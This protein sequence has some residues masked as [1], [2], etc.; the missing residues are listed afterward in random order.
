MVR[1]ESDRGLMRAVEVP[2]HGIRIAYD[3]NMHLQEYVTLETALMRHSSQWEPVLRRFFADAGQDV[4]RAFHRD[5]GLS[6]YAYIAELPDGKYLWTEIVTGVD[7]QIIM[8]KLDDRTKSRVQRQ[9][10]DY[11]WY[12]AGCSGPD[13]IIRAMG[14]KEEDE[15][16]A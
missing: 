2:V 11:E 8:P 13:G 9:F 5:D 12:T 7:V 10:T 6:G 14:I 1:A 15:P 4:V 3:W 16:E